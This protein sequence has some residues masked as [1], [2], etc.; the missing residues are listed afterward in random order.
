MHSLRAAG[1]ER[2]D[3]PHG[4]PELTIGIYRGDKLERVVT[5]KDPRDRFCESYNELSDGLTAHPVSRATSLASSNRR[6]E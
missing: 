6:P 1:V 4:L 2:I 5:M 3:S